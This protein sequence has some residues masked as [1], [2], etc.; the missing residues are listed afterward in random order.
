[1]RRL[2][3]AISF[4]VVCSLLGC[5]SEDKSQ[6]DEQAAES[7][8]PVEQTADTTMPVAADPEDAEDVYP[9]LTW[10]STHTSGSSVS[11]TR[12]LSRFEEVEELTQRYSLDWSNEA[13]ALPSI[14]IDRDRINSLTIALEAT[15]DQRSIIATWRRSGETRAS[16]TAII[17]KRSKP[18]KDIAQGLALMRAYY[19]GKDQF[20]SLIEW[21]VPEAN[22]DNEA[23]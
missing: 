9:R 8:L 2:V 18:L 19:T 15:A 4:A 20:E 3:F 6:P 10:R 22:A 21:T 14:T 5:Y 11:G 17:V 16:T 7:V 12:A 23:Q 1:M 13:E